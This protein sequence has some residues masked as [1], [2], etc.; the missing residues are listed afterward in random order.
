MIAPN[1]Y[2]MQ[3]QSMA[4]ELRGLFAE[5]TLRAITPAWAQRHDPFVRLARTLY[6]AGFRLERLP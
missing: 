2:G 4:A 5:E 6:S 3:V 1:L